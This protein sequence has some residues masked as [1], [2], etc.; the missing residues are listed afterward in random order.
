MYNKIKS[1]ASGTLL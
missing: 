1:F